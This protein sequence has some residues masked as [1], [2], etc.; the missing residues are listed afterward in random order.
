MEITE[1][2]ANTLRRFKNNRHISMIEMANELEI[3][4]STLQDYLSGQGNPSIKTIEHIASKMQIS[5]NFLLSNT[6]S[7]KSL[8]I[9]LPLLESFSLVEKLP[10]EKR[11]KFADLFYELIQ[12]MGDE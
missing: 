10:Q 6:L 3:S 12:L 7:N 8:N 9:I 2:L 4:S 1:N 11:N 5:P